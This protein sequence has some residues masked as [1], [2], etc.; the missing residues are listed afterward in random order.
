M[1]EN[2]FIDFLK[3]VIL[4]EHVFVRAVFTGQRRG[5]DSMRWTR[6]TM[7]PVMLKNGRHLQFSFF[8]ARQNFTYNYAGEELLQQLD[9]L[10]TLP[11]QNLHVTTT[12][13]ILQARYSKKGK[14]LIHRAPAKGEPP[15]PDYFVHDRT[16]RVLMPV[17][18]ASLPY[19]RAVGIAASD[20][21]IKADMRHKYKQLN[22]FLELVEDA[23]AFKAIAQADDTRAR[24]LDAGCGSAYLTFA[25]YH[26]LNH[27]KHTPAHLI[28]IDINGHLVGQHAA[29]ARA[30]EWPHMT[31][32][33][34]AI[35]DYAPE[36]APHMVIALHACDTA[37]DEA[38][39]QGIAWGSD[40]IIC[41]PCCHHH[42]QEQLARRETPRA[43]TAL[44]RH[45]IMSERMGDLL[46]DTF[47]ALI[48]RIMGYKADVVQFVEA[49][50]TPRNLMIRAIKGAPTFEARYLDEYREMKR[51]WSVTPYLEMLLVRYRPELAE[52]LA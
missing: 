21:T 41:A 35:I 44:M 9:A 22:K 42:L 30:L 3:Q 50:H 48:L 24:I 12:Q 8:D 16:K 34:S 39:A 1:S 29:K 37:T 10:F 20:G 45:G 33:K 49:E 2:E 43:F 13:E 23:G 38:I 40:V 19:L 18:E 51:F 11:F 47:R 5:T 17:D 6:F 14:L 15:S 7:R 31:F 32:D 25:V 27:L 4:D 46:T 36:Q 26:Y 52:T 28:G